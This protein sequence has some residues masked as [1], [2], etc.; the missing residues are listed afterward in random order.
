VFALFDDVQ[1][2]T[3]REVYIS[4]PPVFVRSVVEE[5]HRRGVSGSHLHFEEFDFRPNRE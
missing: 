4:G 1:D 3:S 5:L 2:L